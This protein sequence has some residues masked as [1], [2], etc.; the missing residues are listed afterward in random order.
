VAGDAAKNTA[1]EI[2]PKIKIVIFIA[3][4]FCIFGVKP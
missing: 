2:N 3:K 4:Y 1:Q